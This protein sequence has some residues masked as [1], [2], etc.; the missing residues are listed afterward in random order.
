MELVQVNREIFP[1]LVEQTRFI[2]ANTD[3]IDY[4][5]LKNRCTIPVLAKDN[6]STVSHAEFIDL[7]LEAINAQLSGERISNPIIAVSHP[8]KGRIPEGQPVSSLKCKKPPEINEFQAVL[9]LPL[10]WNLRKNPISRGIIRD[11]KLS[12]VVGFSSLVPGGLLA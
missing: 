6:E 3:F 1:E 2:S 5:Q 12:A 11:L 10:P 9:F 4:N 8:I 7:A